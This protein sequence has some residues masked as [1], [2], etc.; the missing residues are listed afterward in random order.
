MVEFGE[1]VE[2]GQNERRVAQGLTPYETRGL[3]PRPELNSPGNLAKSYSPEATDAAS[4]LV[5]PLHPQY[6]SVLFI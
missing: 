6:Y 2:V 4:P 5:V 3:C 1:M